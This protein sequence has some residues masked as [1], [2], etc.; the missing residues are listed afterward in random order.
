MLP[1]TYGGHYMIKRQ[2]IDYM[3]PIGIIEIIGT[4]KGIYSL[5]FSDRD[6]VVNLIEDET[7]EVLLDCY[8]E[9]NDYFK[10]ELLE[11]TF[12]YSHEGTNFQKTVWHA[13]TSVPYAETRSYK[14]IA[15]AI[16]NE[17]KA[18]RA[19][20]SANGKKTN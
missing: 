20:G 1:I 16:G 19:V 9:L 3:S 13:L 6:I 11:F 7:P 12:P 8:K 18:I 2:I 15:V 17:K 10:G 14:D 4:G 5:M